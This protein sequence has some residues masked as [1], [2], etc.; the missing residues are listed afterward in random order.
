MKTFAVLLLSVL[1]TSSCGVST[2]SSSSFKVRMHG[3]HSPPPGA[4][5]TSAP[6]SQVYLF[7]GVTLTKTDATEIS[8]YDGD[9]ETVKIIDR[10]QIIFEKLDMSVYDG[11]DIASV[12]IQFDPTV[13][14]TSKDDNSSTLDLSSGDLQLDEA[15]TVTKNKEQV[16]TIKA[17]WG[18]TITSN[19]DGTETIS[20]PAFTITYDDGD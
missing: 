2:T 8:L 4:D 3:I 10:G 17:A 6:Q 14:V 19:D 12:K 9:P 18:D 15:F 20:P 1:T 13:I 5:G 11:T 7:K 16:I